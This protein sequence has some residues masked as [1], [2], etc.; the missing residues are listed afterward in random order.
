[1]F[2]RVDDD[3]SIMYRNTDRETL[4][5]PLYI[6][7]F[8]FRR[9][10]KLTDAQKFFMKNPDPKK[11][12]TTADK[13]RYYRHMK[14][15]LQKDVAE[16]AGI[17]HGTYITYESGKRRQYDPDE[18]SVIAELFGVTMEDLLDDYNRFLLNQGENIRR[19]RES[20]NLTQPKF[21]AKMGVDCKTVIRWENGEKLMFKRTWEKLM[22]LS[23]N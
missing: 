11:I 8:E 10:C 15:L 20:L 23:K 7:R 12:A 4:Y 14:G 19:I 1:M 16:Y 22:M 3:F 21:A 6:E 9:A 17:E 2:K 18:L 5:A 13:L